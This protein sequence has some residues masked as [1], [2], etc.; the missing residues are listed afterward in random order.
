LNHPLL[1]LLAC[2]ARQGGGGGL[3]TGPDIPLS[4]KTLRSVSR[5]HNNISM[6]YFSYAGL[7]GPSHLHAC[8][9]RDSTLLLSRAKSTLKL[10]SGLCMRERKPFLLSFQPPREQANTDAAQRRSTSSSSSPSRA[11]PIPP[12][13]RKGHKSLSADREAKSPSPPL[14]QPDAAFLSP[15]PDSM[16]GSSSGSCK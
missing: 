9:R 13:S 12:S 6:F 11:L 5:A 7:F 2:E 4:H 3:G 8:I 14:P 15:G 10:E 16:S 1:Q